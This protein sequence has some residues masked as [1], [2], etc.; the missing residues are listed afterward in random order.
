VNRKNV[1]WIV[2]DQ[3][4]AQALRVNGDP[5]AHTP[6]LDMLSK[7]GINLID[8]VSG[9]PLCC[10]FR[11][12]MLTGLYPNK[13]VNA[14]EEGLD[15]SQKTIAHVMN[16]VGYDTFYLGKW[17]LDGFKEADGRAA[18]HVVPPDRRGG[19]KKWIGYENNNSQWDCYVHGDGAEAPYR[20]NGYETDA[21]TDMMI[22]YLEKQ[23][24]K[25]INGEGQPFFAVMSVQPPHDPYVA[26][27]EFMGKYGASKLRYRGN[28]PTTNTILERAG[29]EMTGYYAMIE[30]LDFNIGRIIKT[31]HENNLYFDTHIMFFSDHGDMLGSHGQF[32]KTTPYEEAVRVPFIISG[33]KPMDYEGRG[34]G[35]A[36]GVF[37]NHA[38]IAPTTLG[39]CGIEAPDWM[40]G[41]DYSHY[42]MPG[43]KVYREPD[44]AF[45][46]S[47]V[48]TMHGDSV[49]KPWRGVIT[50]DKWKYV[51]FAEIP[52][53]LFDLR[54][55]PLEQVN[56][57]H[58]QIYKDKIIELNR[59]LGEWIEKTGDNF[60]L[61]VLS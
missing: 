8:A 9:Y 52:W 55:D 44:S 59:K 56:L 54:E 48:P 32:R 27:A 3:L 10:P 47:I 53:L 11:G 39:L 33:E 31:L 51:C 43:N 50:R 26:P 38:D 14:H 40:Q 42:R 21:L 23:G 36:P 18:F 35:R 60:P 30:N 2:S 29:D 20:L 41:V 37:I 34:C 22:E 24:L 58:N 19:F 25:R 61:P 15:P 16:D 13:A 17:H 46:Q 1:I 4:R 6:N 12:S 57:A 5:N 49:N 28:V 7:T 45:L